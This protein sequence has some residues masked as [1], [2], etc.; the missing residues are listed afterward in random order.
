MIFMLIIYYKII[1]IGKL[2]MNERMGRNI[3]AMFLFKKFCNKYGFKIILH[4]LDRVYK[5]FMLH[6]VL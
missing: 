3:S 1:W 5:I 2:I 6:S 4:F